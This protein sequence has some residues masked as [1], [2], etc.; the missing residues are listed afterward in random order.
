MSDTPYCIEV[1][2][3]PEGCYALVGYSDGRPNLWRFRNGM[4]TIEA[5]G[6]KYVTMGHFREAVLRGL[7]PV[8]RP[9]IQ[10][11]TPYEDP[12]LLYSFMGMLII[13]TPI[14]AFC[15]AMGWLW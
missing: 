2:T 6:S 5:P 13:M 3:Y 11:Q 8:V 14:V 15:Y 9:H 12:P 4:E 10:W 7:K 1:K